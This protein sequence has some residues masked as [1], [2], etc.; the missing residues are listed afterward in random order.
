MVKVYLLNKS[1]AFMICLTLWRGSNV[2]SVFGSQEEVKYFR[3]FEQNMTGL[4][5]HNRQNEKSIP[6]MSLP[7][8]L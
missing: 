8:N 4:T 3:Y 7:W 2:A 5:A 1:V 6:D